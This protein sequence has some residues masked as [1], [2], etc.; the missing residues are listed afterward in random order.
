MAW[1]ANGARFTIAQ[2]ERLLKSKT[3]AVGRLQRKRDGLQRKLD[4]LDRE[5]ERL[6]GDSAN[7]SRRGGRGTSSRNEHN[8]PDTIQSVLRS[9]GKPMRV[10][11]IADAVLASGYR[12]GSANFRGI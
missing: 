8:L 10:P 6:G 12:S 3:A 1:P 2:L 11:D 7:G 5:I 9:A 4:A